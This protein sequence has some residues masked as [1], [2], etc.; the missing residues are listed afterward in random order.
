MAAS[1]PAAARRA[2]RGMPIGNSPAS[3][4]IHEGRRDRRHADM[5]V[6]NNLVLFDPLVPQNTFES[7]LI[8]PRAGHGTGQDRAYFSSAHRSQVARWHA[9]WKRRET[10]W[11]AGPARNFGSIR[12]RAGTGTWRGQV[13]SDNE[14]TFHLQRPQPSLLALLAPERRRFTVS[15]RPQMRQHRLIR[16]V[17]VRRVQTKRNHQS[18]AQSGW[19][20]GRPYLD[21]IEYSIIERIDT[22]AGSLP[23]IRHDLSVRGVDPVAEGCQKRAP[24]AICGLVWTMA[25]GRCR[26]PR[27]AA[28]RQCRSAAG[29]GAEP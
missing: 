8:S 20:P 13:D 18:G 12:A 19:K 3:M 26:Q 15:Y 27:G 14:V 11:P 29:N 28:F 7:G 5:A 23:E 10:H 9:V 21:G 16:P 2:S 24:R 6:F 17:Q 1:W 4:S 22:N 25:A